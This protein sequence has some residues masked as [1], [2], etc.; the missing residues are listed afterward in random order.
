MVRAIIE[1]R[2]TMTRREVKPQFDDD[3]KIK[4]G[5]IGTSKGIAYVGNARSGGLDA[6]VPCPYGRPGDRL[7]VRETWGPGPVY[8]AD[9]ES[10]QPSDGWRPSI[11][12]PRKLSRITLEIT[13]VRVERLQEI[14]EE[15]AKAEGCKAHISPASGVD[16]PWWQGYKEL[17]GDLIH[18]QYRGA[19]PPDWMIDPKKMKELPHLNYDVVRAF[20]LLWESIKGHGSWALNPW[21]WVI[22]FKKQDQL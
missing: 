1:G 16:V 18:Q 14:S 3:A 11:F 21:V 20:Q 13:D 22:E 17:S 6:R 15:N 19:A 8:R 12:M 10:Q 4:I 9:D 7:W 2:K 5:E